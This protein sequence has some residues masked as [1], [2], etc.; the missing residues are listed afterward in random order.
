MSQPYCG[1]LS[2]RFLNDENEVTSRRELRVIH[3]FLKLGRLF[4]CLLTPHLLD[5]ADEVV[6]L[7]LLLNL[8]C[9]LAA[10]APLTHGKVHRYSGD[11]QHQDNRYQDAQER[12]VAA[13]RRQHGSSHETNPFLSRAAGQ[14]R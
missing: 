1:R 12:D 3:R 5:L 8:L 11:Q 4:P 14:P 2:K 13:P 6:L 10:T 9:A 7:T